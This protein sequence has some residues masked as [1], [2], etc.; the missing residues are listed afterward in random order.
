MLTLNALPESDIINLLELCNN[1]PKLANQLVLNVNNHPSIYHKTLTGIPYVLFRNNFMQSANINKIIGVKGTIIRTGPVLLKN[2]KTEYNCLKCNSIGFFYEKPALILCETCGSNSVFKKECL[3][4]S[5]KTQ[6][7]K[8]QN[9]GNVNKFTDLYEINIEGNNAGLFVAGQE[10][11]V[12]GILSLKWKVLKNNEKIQTALNIKALH[13]SKIENYE[14]NDND[15]LDCFL[16]FNNLSSFEK[17]K[18]L[19]NSFTTEIYG[20]SNIKLG[21]LLVLVNE[22][23]EEKKI[24]NQTRQ[25]SHVLLIGDSGTGKTC[26]LNTTSKLITPSILT[27]GVG[28]SNAGLTSCAIKQGK[29]WS[30]EAGALLLADMGICCI[31]EFNKLKINEKGGL[32]EAMEQQTLSVAKAGILTTFNA[33][34]S[35]IAACNIRYQYENNKTVSENTCISTPLVSRFDLIFGMFDTKD[36][37]KDAK[38]A[39][40]I[41]NRQYIVTKEK[42]NNEWNINKLKKF[43]KHIRKNDVKISE[44]M[45]N[46]LLTY[47]LKRKSTEGPNEFNT[48]RMLE[49]LVRISESHAKILGKHNVDEEDIYSAILLL[50]TCINS[51]SIIKTKFD[52]LFINQKIYNDCV[53]IIKD[54]YKI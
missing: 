37:C 31:D 42:S 52:E 15:F 23:K 14:E 46:K 44:N 47:Y 8:I 20:Y 6:S 53:E 50:E 35:I 33:R 18:I 32:L 51:T 9:I 29:D 49:S 45:S 30:L 41:L 10:V 39:D 12:V 38:I 21:L 4:E 25:I 16:D 54:T 7:I 3:N 36:N 26:F 2:I 48:V 1:D 40:V 24:T 17:R 19:I 11:I 43:I 27:N 28:T 22:H 5:I 34:C 13:I